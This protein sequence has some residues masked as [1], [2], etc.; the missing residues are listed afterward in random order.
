[1]RDANYGVSQGSLADV[2]HF[3]GIVSES[4]NKQEFA[5]RSEMIKAA[6]Y[7]WQRDG[8]GQNEGFRIRR[9][10]SLPPDCEGS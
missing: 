10:A 9:T 7:T 8:V 4:G 1:M 5:A 3:D 6:F 2:D